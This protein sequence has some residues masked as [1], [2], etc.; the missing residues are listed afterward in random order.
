M[1]LTEVRMTNDK[2][3]FVRRERGMLASNFFKSPCSS[4]LCHPSEKGWA[5]FFPFFRPPAGIRGSPGRCVFDSWLTSHI[6][7][8]AFSRLYWVMC[9]GI[10]FWLCPSAVQRVLR[11]QEFSMTFN[12]DVIRGKR[13]SDPCTHEAEAAPLPQKLHFVLQNFGDR[14]EGKKKK[15]WILS[16]ISSNDGICSQTCSRMLSS[17]LLWLPW[18]P[19]MSLQ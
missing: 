14:N 4:L 2:R 13:F 7:L 11:D 15:R 6:Q 12:G 1:T 19:L 3:R 8:T 5:N 18:Q 16:L 10:F 17:A 9:A